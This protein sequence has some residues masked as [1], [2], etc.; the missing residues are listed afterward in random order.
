[1]ARAIELTHAAGAQAFITVNALMRDSD[2]KALRGYVRFLAEAQADAVIVSDVGALALIREEA[3]E[4]AVHVSTQASVTNAASARAYQA[5]GAKRI[6]L[7][8]ELSLKEIAHLAD[9]LG[10]DG[11]ELEVFVHGAMCMSY[12]G[13][14]LLS[15]A[16]T[17]RDA[18]R[19][20]CAQP[21]RWSY[22]LVEETRPG[23]YMPIEEDESGSFVLS[24]QDLCMI[25]H[26]D[27]LKDAGVASIKIE[28]RV[29]SAYYVATVVNAYRHV[30][31]EASAA[32]YRAELDC[33][34]HRPYST[35]FFFGTA[36]QAEG[37]VSYDQSCDWIATVLECESQEQGFRITV[38]QR[39][40][41]EVGETLE[42]LSPGE[43][44]RSF[45]VAGLSDEWGMPQRIAN[46]ATGTY[47]LDCPL[48]LKPGDLL[49]RRRC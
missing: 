39:N 28:G 49:R 43:P 25:E 26:L 10:D 27:E 48:P 30:L 3:P 35:G 24:A 19:G 38:G 16:L 4:L 44:L 5:L 12:S 47:M 20:A 9:E 18:N 6:V 17:G 23:E 33:V 15:N 22:A 32:D 45:E 40:R 42:V 13:R 34:S 37:R 7:A 1:M 21:C 8:R 41:F 31:D 46:R 14:C 2:L 29:K 36:G 11:P